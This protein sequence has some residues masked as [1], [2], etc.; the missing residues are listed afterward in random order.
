[1]TVYAAELPRNLGLQD[2][3]PLKA[4][5]LGGAEDRRFGRKYV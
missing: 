5:V 4:G 2:Q 1:M 3:V